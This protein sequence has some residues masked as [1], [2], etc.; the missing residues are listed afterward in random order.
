MMRLQP[1]R[2]I[3]V[4]L[5]TLVLSAT[6]DDSA[7]AG[8]FEDADAAY[9][10]GDFSTTLALLKKPAQLGNAR[11]QHNLGVLYARGEGVAQNYAEA[12]MWYQRSAKQGYVPAQ[13]KIGMIYAEARGLPRD[14]A[15][16][17][18]WL[19][20]AATFGIVVAIKERDAI[21]L[22]LTPAQIAEGDRFATSWKPVLETG[23]VEIPKAERPRRQKR[24]RRR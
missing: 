23:A 3:A 8:L 6:H 1:N 4:I 7:R 13:V 12:A 5:A 9:A 20:V 10:S 18:K 15:N 19:S 22:K 2:L 16:A 21:A 17:Y 11:P 24:T 14:L